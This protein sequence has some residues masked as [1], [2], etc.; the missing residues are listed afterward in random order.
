VPV[1]LFADER[2]GGGAPAIRLTDDLRALATSLQGG[3]LAVEAESRW[4]LVETVW[5]LDL[6]RAGV[7]VEADIGQGLLY[8]KR[9]R[10]V[11]LTGVRGALNGYQRGRCF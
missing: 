7:A 6:P 11:N 8:V 1:R 2:G 9:I 3:G 5:A 10:G 4:R